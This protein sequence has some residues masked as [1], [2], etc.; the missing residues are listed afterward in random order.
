MDTADH[1]ST[2]SKYYDEIVEKRRDFDA[3]A[4]TLATLIGKRKSILDIGIGTGSVVEKLLQVMPQHCEFW[5]IDN[6][7]SL[8]EQARAKPGLSGVQLHLA[9]VLDFNLRRDFEAAYSRGGAFF[10]MGSPEETIFAS[11]LLSQED[12]LR[13]LNSTAKHLQPSGLFLLSIV[14]F[15]Q[16]EEKEI[17]DGVFYCRNTRRHTE[18]GQ[19]HLTI[20]LSFKK[21][22]VVIDQQVLKL[23]L[24]DCNKSQQ[25]FLEAGFHHLGLSPDGTYHMYTKK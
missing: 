6:S 21:D 18:N 7:R 12:N 5:G 23:F 22:S 24:M 10:F 3:I 8:L 1:Y 17:G 15:K 4:H 2:Y 11:H 16:D 19:Q 9:D 14:D 25:M 13:A 20:E